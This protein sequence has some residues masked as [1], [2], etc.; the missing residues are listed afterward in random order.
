MSANARPNILFLF[1]DDQRFDT[2]GALG[3]PEV[4]TPAM[5]SLVQRGTA[6]TNAYIMGGSCGAVCMP[7]RAMLM[8]G[9]TL[10]HLEEQG[11]RI[12]EDHVLLGEI[13]QAAGYTTFGTG[14]WHNGPASYA[15]SFTTGAEIFF[16]GMDDH[17]NVP[18]S[19][20]DPTGSYDNVRPFIR[21]PFVT[22]QVSRRHVD[23]IRPGVH[24]SELFAGAAVDFLQNHDG[25]N[26]FFMYV[27][28]MAP[29]DPRTMPRE[30]LDMYDP[31]AV[32]LPENF[33]PTHPFDN[34]E[35][36]VRDELLADFPRTTD[37]VRR[38]IA[39]YY[40]MITH[41]DAQI[42]RIVSTLEARGWTENTIF[43][44]AGDNGLAIGRHGLMGKQNLY[45]HSLHV[46]LLMAGPGVP[47]G[48]TRDAYT[49]LLDIAPTLCDLIG[50]PVP[51]TVEG[52]SLMPTLQNSDNRVRNTL[53]FA[54]RGYQRA[55]QDER[56]KLIEYVVEGRR[57][58]Q[59]FDLHDDPWELRNL[60]S[61]PS[62]RDRV[63]ALRQEM[64][65]WRD[66]LDDDQPGQ[67]AA[68]W[69]RFDA[70]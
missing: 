37:E 15:R 29:H 42:G 24:S 11:Q 52:R 7:S 20:F 68:F 30:Y 66:A 13:L 27:S 50:Q 4:I 45:D 62:H 47:K 69:S 59:L 65:R 64:R 38:H 3:H 51:V 1:T 46:P 12:P 2:I 48:E 41:L 35:L 33:M 60:A 14:K 43:V 61:D 8:T 21:D 54:Y 40:A 28:F 55:V 22:N 25:N 26:P 63:A 32:T 34:G 23:H 6:F 57:T 18:A 49:Y 19:D 10:Y 17:W 70:T 67:G 36:Q 5:D 16:G 39:E 31:T 56:Y 58:T 44:L 53:Y 9:R